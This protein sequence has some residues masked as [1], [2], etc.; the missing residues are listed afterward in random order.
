[1][2]NNLDF[3]RFMEC[4]SVLALMKKFGYNIPEELA[5]VYVEAILEGLK[6]LHERGV[7]HCDLKVNHLYKALSSHNSSIYPT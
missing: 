2:G 7:V 5:S 6:Y 1:M 3:R 4:G